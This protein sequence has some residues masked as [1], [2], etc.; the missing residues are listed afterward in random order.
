MLW[1]IGNVVNS[2]ISLVHQ[3]NLQFICLAREID[4][5]IGGDLNGF[6][7][8]EPPSSWSTEWLQELDACPDG[9]TS[10]GFTSNLIQVLLVKFSEL[11]KA[12]G[13]IW[14]NWNNILVYLLC[15]LQILYKWE[16]R[17]RGVDAHTEYSREESIRKVYI[18]FEVV[19]DEKFKT[20]I[21]SRSAIQPVNH[22]IEAHTVFYKVPAELRCRIFSVLSP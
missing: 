6:D 9:L 2:N 3:Y 5:S 20:G 15:V 11:N 8:E 18:I 12:R 13:L 19:D 16:L 4:W 17:I 14:I 10:L 7:A 21:I 1:S 22:S